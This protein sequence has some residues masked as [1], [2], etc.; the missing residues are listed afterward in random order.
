M[1]PCLLLRVIRDPLGGHRSVR[2]PCLH[3]HH[4]TA[5]GVYPQGKSFAKFT[6][7]EFRKYN[8][9]YIILCI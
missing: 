6:Q 7:E 3:G 9:L 8:S 5:G 1:L 4:N 2:W